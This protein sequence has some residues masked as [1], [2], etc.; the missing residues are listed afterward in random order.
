MAV[1]N[2]NSPSFCRHRSTSKLSSDVVCCWLK[3]N[4]TSGR[5]VHLTLFQNYPEILGCRQH[6]LAQWMKVLWPH[7]WTVRFDSIS[8]FNV[9]RSLSVGLRPHRGFQ[10]FDTNSRVKKYI[11]SHSKINIY[12]PINSS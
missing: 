10:Y 5:A 9:Q 1:V 2:S 12:K 11:V 7:A 6:L 4:S 8:A 3:T